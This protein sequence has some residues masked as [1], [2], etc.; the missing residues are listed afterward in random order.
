MRDTTNPKKFD[1]V[2]ATSW[3]ADLADRDALH[4][5]HGVKFDDGSAFDANTVKY[6]IDRI[7]G[8]LPGEKTQPLSSFQYTSLE[9]RQGGQPDDGRHHHEDA[10]STAAGAAVG[11]ADDPDRLGHKDP[12]AL[13]AKPDGTGPYSSS[14]WDRNNQV[15]MKAK[16]NY[17]RGE[18]EDRQRDLQGHAR[19][20]V[21]ARGA[22]S[23][24]TST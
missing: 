17:F 15:V 23:P 19:R 5:P 8:T 4:A 2:L 22:R 6:N 24:G 3:Q 7:M 1:G 18:A 21:A 16:P 14:Q 20:R 10:R 9:G 13:A 11:A 12:N